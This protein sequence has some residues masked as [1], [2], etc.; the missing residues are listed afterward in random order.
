MGKLKSRTDE[1]FLPET[2]LEQSEVEGAEFQLGTE[3][4]LVVSKTYDAGASARL[5]SNH[6]FSLNDKSSAWYA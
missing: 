3:V 4:D 5:V 6:E 1:N 2:V